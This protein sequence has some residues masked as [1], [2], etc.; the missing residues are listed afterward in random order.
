MDH[1]PSSRVSFGCPDELLETLDE[2]TEREDKNRSEKLRELVQKEV[3]AKGDL[4]EPQPVLPDDER[5][6]EAYRM[7]H[8]RASA[9]H[10]SKR[11][12]KLET[13]KNKLYDN[14]TPKSAS[15]VLD[16]IIKPLESEGYVSVWAG[17]QHVWVIVPPMRYTDGED[18]VDAGEKA[19]A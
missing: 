15:A 19:V 12:V 14:T 2:I 16:E 7:L 17:N 1:D 3:E 9:R 8:E 11:R 6:A 4:D 5:L 13:A 10:K 18:I